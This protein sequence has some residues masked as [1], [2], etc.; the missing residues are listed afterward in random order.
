[1][2][3]QLVFFKQ[4]KTEVFHTES[5]EKW[6][7]NL[8]KLQAYAVE[9][10]YRQYSSFNCGP[11]INSWVFFFGILRGKC[12]KI[13]GFF[14]VLH[15]NVV[16]NLFFEQ[17]LAVYHIKSYWKFEVFELNNII[18]K[19]NLEFS[20]QIETVKFFFLEKSIEF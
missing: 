18:E 19:I 11:G 17:I 1:M 2:E 16:R 4:K 13:W 14:W 12:R 20:Q 5:Q 10:T 3:Q 8:R 9:A 15:W 7:E 6:E